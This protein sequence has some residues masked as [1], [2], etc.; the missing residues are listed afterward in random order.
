MFGS[1]IDIHYRDEGGRTHEIDT[2]GIS[3]NI[4]M[5]GNNW[6]DIMTIVRTKLDDALRLENYEVRCYPE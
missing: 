2:S 1:Y 3:Y 4:S 6:T 5:I